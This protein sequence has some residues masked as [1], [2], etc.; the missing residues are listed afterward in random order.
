M[1][2][3]STYNRD[4]ITWAD[5]HNL[6]P[7]NITIVVG[8][9]GGPD[10]VFLLQLLA[11]IRES[12]NLSL[13][14]AHLDHGWRENSQQDVLFC[15]KIATQYD[16]TFASGHANDFTQKSIN[17]SLEALGRDARR[18]FF[19]DVARRYNAHCIALGHHADDQLETLF[20]RL[21][22]GAG[23]TGLAGIRPRNG[24]FIHPLLSARKKDILEFLAN[25]NIPF[26]IDETNTDRR[27]LRNR[28]RHDVVPVLSSAD[29]R[30][31]SSA[32]RSIALL[33]QAHNF[34]DEETSK[35]LDSIGENRDGHYWIDYNKLL[36]L[37]PFLCKQVILA[38]MIR[39]HVPFT[40][41]QNLINEII[42]FLANTKATSHQVYQT[43]HIVKKQCYACVRSSE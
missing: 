39:A 8:L 19:E 13:I 32:E 36:M 5:H 34:I 16:V 35:T 37:H 25:K 1:L 26:L 30:F 11:S 6:I 24:I 23:L 43:W 31:I 40:P 14:A 10:S 2:K 12:R 4:I 28:I 9:S 42:R 22:R 18:T 20:I 41:S 3:I 27:F 38:W 33:Q 21:A 29:A 7:P 15:Q 17:G